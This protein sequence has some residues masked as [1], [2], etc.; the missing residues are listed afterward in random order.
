MCMGAEHRTAEIYI[1]IRVLSVV[2]KVNCIPLI[3]GD[4]TVDRH[5]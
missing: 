4:G 3:S 2:V 1:S 5:C